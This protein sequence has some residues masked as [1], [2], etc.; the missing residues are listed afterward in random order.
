MT[1]NRSPPFSKLGEQFFAKSKSRA[2]FTRKTLIAWPHSRWEAKA[3]QRHWF[4]PIANGFQFG[5]RHG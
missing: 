3:G 2:G 1:Q 5:N 4:S